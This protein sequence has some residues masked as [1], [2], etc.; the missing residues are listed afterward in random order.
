MNNKET[1]IFLVGCTEEELANKIAEIVFS[2]MKPHFP[3]KED[4]L[5]TRKE[6]SRILNISP[7]TL[8]A[9]V[10]E[11]IIQVVRIGKKVLIRQSELDKA[12]LV[13]RRYKRDDLDREAA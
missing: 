9:R 2:L 1:R 6:A 4:K 3:E 7:Q 12:L 8:D 5:L 10:R 13:I 11:G